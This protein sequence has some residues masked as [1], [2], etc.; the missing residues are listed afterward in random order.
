MLFCIDY[1]F[2][3]MYIIYFLITVLLV[4]IQCDCFP[5]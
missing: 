5:S 4:S 2:R 1:V 3:L